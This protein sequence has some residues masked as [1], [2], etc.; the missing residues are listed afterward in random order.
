MLLL[1]ISSVGDNVIVGSKDGKLCWFDTDLSTRPYKALKYDSSL[2]QPPFENKRTSK[3]SRSSYCIA[4]VTIIDTVKVSTWYM[5]NPTTMDVEV[6]AS[7]Q[8][9]R[10]QY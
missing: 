6:S 7:L 9:N 1:H 5:K 3:F 10:I 2:I 4:K 8:N